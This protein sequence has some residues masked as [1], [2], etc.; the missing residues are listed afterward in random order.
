LAKNEHEKTNPLILKI[1][2]TS[3]E[4]KV[5][6]YVDNEFIKTTETFH[7]I[8]ILPTAGK[9]TITVV[10]AQGNELNQTIFIER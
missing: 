4:T 7:E 3:P 8:G 10:D 2:H 9:H 5:F 1:A 6:W